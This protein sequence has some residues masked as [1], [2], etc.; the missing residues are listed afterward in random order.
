MLRHTHRLVQWL[1]LG[2]IVGIS[3]GLGSAA[4][5][6]LLDLATGIRIEREYLVYA[7][8]LAGLAMGYVN[9][10]WG[11]AVRAGNNL[12][13]D[14]VHSDSQRV[15]FRMAPM[16]LIGSVMTH[17]FGGSAGR[18]GAAV[19]VGVALSD[20][21]SHRLRLSPALRT[22]LLAAGI[23]GGFG[24]VFGTPIAGTVFGLE[25]VCLGRMEYRSLVPALVSAVAGD[26]TVRMLGVS[27]AHYPQLAATPLDPLLLL[28]WIVF[29]IAIA[30]MAI[31]FIE[32]TDYLKRITSERIPLLPLRMA[33][34]G[35][36]VVVLWRV[37]GHSDFL[38]LGIPTIERAFYDASLPWYY[39][40]G[41]L[42]FTAVTLSVGF[43]GG[44]VTPLFFMGS[45]LGNVLGR[46]LGIPIQLAAGVGMAGAFAAASN[47]P[48]ALSIMAVEILGA[49]ALPHVVVVCAV[50]YLMTGRRSIYPSQRLLF[51]KTGD[52]VHTEPLPMR[53]SDEAACDLPRKPDEKP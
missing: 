4:F 13:I 46:L 6:V 2:A 11:A 5:I 29:G 27:H 41:K 30:L 8:P 31:A 15:P 45:A 28:K 7:L 9:M 44:E 47:T 49:A 37:V 20:D 21:I 33:A 23:A 53:G 34:G 52:H 40:A 25:V 38:G 1:V 14:S 17:L 24:S 43:L 19:Q 36:M 18:E 22:N 35:A 3:C 39:F 42:V 10:R 50:A 48:L 32:L 26:W 51:E 12:V 16:V